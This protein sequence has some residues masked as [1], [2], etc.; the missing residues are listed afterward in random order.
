MNISFLNILNTSISASWI[1]L[2]VIGLRLLLKKAPKAIHCALWAIVALRL[3]CPFTIESE[4]SLIPSAQT[5]SEDYLT[6][7]GNFSSAPVVLDVVENPAYAGDVTIEL[8]T[9]SHRVGI[10]D[11]KWTAIVWPAGILAM[12]V[13][14]L[15]SYLRIRRKINASIQLGD[16]LWLCDYID[17][18]FIL[19]IFRPRIYLPS[20]MDQETL[21][22]VLAHEM[23]H[24]KRRDH[25][26]KPLG[27]LLLTIHWFNPLMWIAYILLCRD[28]ELACD[29]KVIQMLGDQEKKAYSSALLRCSVSRPIIAACPLAFGEVGVKKRVK[30]VLNYKKPAFWIVLLAVILCIMVAVCFL[31]DPIKP[32]L[33]DILYQNR[34]Q[35]LVQAEQH[36][37]ISIPKSALPEDIFSAEGHTFGEKEVIVYRTDTSTIYLKKA[38]LS[39]ESDDQMYF[40]FDISYDFPKVGTILLPTRV[41]VGTRTSTNSFN[42]DSR[43]LCDGS[44]YFDNAVSVRGQNGL[45]QFVMYI[46]TDA[47]KQARGD[48]TFQMYMNQ[49]T[50]ARNGAE[51]KLNKASSHTITDQTQP[52]HASGDNVYDLG[53][54]NEQRFVFLDPYIAFEALMRDYADAIRMIQE[55]Y[56]LAPLT[57]FAYQDYK[58]YG[59]DSDNEDC[60]TVARFLDFYENSFSDGAGM[61]DTTPT[62]Q[63]DR[64]AV[65]TYRAQETIYWNPLSS[66]LPGSFTLRVMDSS[67]IIGNG[68]PLKIDWEWQAECPLNLEQ[69][70]AYYE[71][72]EILHDEDPILGGDCVYQPLNEDY[73]LAKRYDGIYLV[74]WRNSTKGP[75]IIWFIYRMVPESAYISPGPFT[76]S[77]DNSISPP[78]EYVLY[79]AIR[80]EVSN[81]N[82][83]YSMV[84]HYTS[85]SLEIVQQLLACGTATT[86]GAPCGYTTVYAVARVMT[87][88]ILDDGLTVSQDYYFPL[89]I[90]FDEYP[91]GALVMTGYWQCPNGANVE[92]TLRSRYYDYNVEALLEGMEKYAISTE[93]ACYA[94]AVANYA[95]DTDAMLKELKAAYP[96]YFNLPT[97]HGLT[98]YWW[99][100]AS[101][102]RCTI[103]AG[104]TDDT[105]SAVSSLSLLE[106]ELILSTYD[107]ENI[108]YI[109]T[110]AVR[111]Q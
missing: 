14:A 31:T 10:W 26:W 39:N 91:N 5:I 87:F 105:I 2:A 6:Q 79:E 78:E 96:Q 66:A 23:A 64:L 75:E 45:T 50:Y 19:G 107:T 33:E 51:P 61:S 34:Y 29:E 94:D 101:G 95:V 81:R 7:E 67:V 99:P 102:I 56:N 90:S 108:T 57:P 83:I 11:I 16:R 12:A 35:V 41:E 110:E 52:F 65:D 43:M 36:L 20:D 69:L 71:Y 30:N 55:D 77:T 70:A 15:V 44:I 25:W 100:N 28:I 73:F 97:N 92:E 58:K 80:E 21:D 82:Y 18:P 9:A 89:E 42:L 60:R 8:D 106:A 22:H 76:E 85:V 48:L 98:V 103:T 38:Q 63:A 4:F 109:Q 93:Q 84:P 13:Y 72:Y 68:D 46:D 37:D 3:L 74:K 53:R 17:S 88:A 49:L 54:T 24:L 104:T 47:V 27:F 111:S 59:A 62:T 1:V 32:N 86:D 40:T